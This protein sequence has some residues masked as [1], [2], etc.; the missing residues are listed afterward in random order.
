VSRKRRVSPTCCY[1]GLPC[2][3]TGDW[4]RDNDGVYHWDCVPELARCGAVPVGTLFVRCSKAKG[5]LCDHLHVSGY[6]WSQ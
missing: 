4:A 1:C 3:P 6:R 2:A 5:H